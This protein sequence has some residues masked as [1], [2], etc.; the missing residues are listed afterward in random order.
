VDV[1]AI[2]STLGG[3]DFWTS[4]D[5]FVVPAGTPV[6]IGD[7]PPDVLLEAETP[8]DVYVRVHNHGCLDLTGLGVRVYS[9]NPAMILDS[10]A[11]VNITPPGTFVPPGG[12]SVARGAPVLLGPFPWTPTAEEAISN[13]GHRC[14][15][16]A[17]DA[18]GDPL[19]TAGVPDNNNFAQR[20]LQFGLTSFSY[21]NPGANSA[22]FETDLA[23][24]GFPLSAPGAKLALRVAYHPAIHLAW[25]GA[26]GATITLD[27]NSLLVTFNRCNVRLPKVTLPGKTLLPASFDAILPGHP[28][29]AYTVDLGVSSGGQSL[30][31]MSFRS[32]P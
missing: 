20:N 1:G 32:K 13:L 4:P 18:P 2:P 29:G 24:N 17:I 19:G 6:G 10:S 25:S 28:P 23:C 30:G 5:I 7:T 11:W 12:V 31:G 22:A 27:G 16:A 9:A 8:Y 21:G 3:H 14:M 26:E 15:L